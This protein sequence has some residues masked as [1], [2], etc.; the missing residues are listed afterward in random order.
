MEKKNWNHNDD[1]I[2]NLSDVNSENYPNPMLADVVTNK[3]FQ[4]EGTTNKNERT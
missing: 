3:I 1:S 2:S 4:K